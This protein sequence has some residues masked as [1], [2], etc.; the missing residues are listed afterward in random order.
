MYPPPPPPPGPSCS[1]RCGTVCC[2]HHRHH[3]RCMVMPSMEV[4]AATTTVPPPPPPPPP[5]LVAV[6]DCPLVPLA[7][8]AASSRDTARIN[9]HEATTSATRAAGALGS[10][11]HRHRRHPGT[12]VLGSLGVGVHRV[13]RALVDSRRPTSYYQGS[14][15]VGIQGRAGVAVT[16]ASTADKHRAIGVIEARVE[17]PGERGSTTDWGIA[18][19]PFHSMSL[20]PPP[21]PPPPPAAIR[22]P[23]PPPLAAAPRPYWPLS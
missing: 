10:H 11:H 6:A 2:R 1:G 19:W 23:P 5:L 15:S 9:E 20:S 8:N 14:Q 17:R 18:P 13:R 16:A 3:S 21:P 12:P 22:L 4:L 7:D